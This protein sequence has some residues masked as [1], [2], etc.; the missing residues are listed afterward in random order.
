MS[1]HAAGRKL[2]SGA[3]VALL[4]SVSA[5]GTDG[6]TEAPHRCPKSTA[7]LRS[8]DGAIFKSTCALTTCHTPDGFAG[9]N[10]IN[11]ETPA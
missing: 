4:I 5:C 9:W 11:S 2:A 1:A 3:L 10:K 7:Q 8:I 6:E